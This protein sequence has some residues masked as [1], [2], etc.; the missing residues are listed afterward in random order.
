MRTIGFF[1]DYKGKAVLLRGSGISA[2][3]MIECNQY[4]GIWKPKK[5][6]SLREVMCFT[7]KKEALLAAKKLRFPLHS[8]V[9]YEG[10]LSGRIWALQYDCRYNYLLAP[11]WNDDIVGNVVLS[12]T[13]LRHQWTNNWICEHCGKKKDDLEEFKN[14]KWNN[15]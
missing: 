14:Y 13:R 6:N 2:L 8:V 3:C 12:C 11:N 5:G 1:E 10:R 9:K 15:C 4:A 7:T